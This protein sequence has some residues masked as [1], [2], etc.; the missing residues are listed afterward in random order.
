MAI[1]FQ[2]PGGLFLF[3]LVLL[4]AFTD[5]AGEWILHNWVMISV[6][7]YV[8]EAV[9]GIIRC[10]RYKKGGVS[11]WLTIPFTALSIWAS[12]SYMLL[13]VADI[14]EIASGGVL[15]LL[16]LIIAAPLGLLSCAVCKA[17]AAFVNMLAKDR[18]LGAELIILDGIVTLVLCLLCRW[19]FGFPIL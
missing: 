11:L 19:F 1:I 6:I 4:M 8:V 13:V 5:G 17:P 10:V 15:G 9:R 3:A 7:S 12:T 16:G 14:A 2:V 18:E